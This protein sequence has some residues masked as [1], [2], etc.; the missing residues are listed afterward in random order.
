MFKIIARAL[1]ATALAATGLAQA[2]VVTL[3]GR[4]DDATNQA[5]VGSFGELPVFTADPLDSMQNVALHSFSLGAGQAVRF[6]SLGYAA[7]GIDPYVSLFLGTGDQATFLRSFA[8][9]TVG[10]F[11]E[12][13]S[14]VPG[15]YTLAIGLYSNMSFAENF[16]VGTLGD[17]FTGLGGSDFGTGYYELVLTTR[18]GNEVP[19]PG[20]LYLVLGAAAAAALTHRSLSRRSSRVHFVRAP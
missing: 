11:D 18:D 3:S 5:L 12:I 13:E 15:N 2:A 10:D 7:G 1:V 6:E 19:E 4:L 9:T 16:G 8:G 17:G 14:L 20:S